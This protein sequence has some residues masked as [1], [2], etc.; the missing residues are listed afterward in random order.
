[1]SFEKGQVYSSEPSFIGKKLLRI[2]NGKQ[3]KL[4]KLLHVFQAKLKIDFSCLQIDSHIFASDKL[5]FSGKLG[6]MEQMQ[7]NNIM[8][9]KVLF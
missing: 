6:Q 8:M 2:W 3:I 4:V 1:M 7:T 5:F 9:N